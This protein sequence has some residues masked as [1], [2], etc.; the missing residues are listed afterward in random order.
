[1][2]K[3]KLWIWAIVLV[4]GISTGLTSCSDEDDAPLEDMPVQPS[5]EG[6]QGVKNPRQTAIGAKENEV[7]WSCIEFGSYP[8]NE[9][10]SGS[11]DAVDGYAVREGDVIRDAALYEKLVK[12]VWTDDETEMD[13]RRYR[14]I[15][16]K[17]A[18]SAATGREQH[19]RWVDVEAWHY[20]EYV[21]MKWRVL[22]IDGSVAMLLADRMPDVCPFNDEAV[23]V[24]WEQSSL[25]RWLNGEFL[26]RAFSANE[27][28]AIL[29]TDLENAPNYYFGTSSGTATRDRVFL[30]SEK[31]IFVTETAKSFGF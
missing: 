29:T 15:N 20:F 14:R 17:G 3:N 23:D 9:V 5:E 16:G 12:A 13:G 28:T 1:M 24:C 11:F 18:V 10:V 8:A 7:T 26:D 19:Y 22:R 21:P 4:C 30:L 25:R 6:Y 31:E 27:Q 2:K